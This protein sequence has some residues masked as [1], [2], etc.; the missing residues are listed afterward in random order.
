MSEPIETPHAVVGDGYCQDEPERDEPDE[1][2]E[3]KDVPR[4]DEDDIK[5]VAKGLVEGHIFC[6]DMAPEDMWPMIFMPLGMGAQLNYD[7]DQIGNVYEWLDKAGERGINGF[8]MFLSCKLAH[9]DDWLAVI[10]RAKKIE[11]AVKAA[12]E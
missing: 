6:L 5:K 9:K 2:I 7:M 12:M 11:D 10:E 1:P 3:I 8:P 4:M